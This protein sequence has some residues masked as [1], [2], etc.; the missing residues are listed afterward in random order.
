MFAD[1][2]EFNVD[3]SKWD[4]SSVTDMT[5]MFYGA[6]S[7]HQTLCSEAW[8]KSGATKDFIFFDS[9]GSISE[10]LCRALVHFF[11]ILPKLKP[12]HPQHP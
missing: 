5:V 4:V 1:E 7:F 11:I 12:C 10:T 8:I 9:P 6:S 3:L 2:T